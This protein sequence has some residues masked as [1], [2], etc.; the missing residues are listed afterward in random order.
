M[1]EEIELHPELMKN[2]EI[3][4]LWGRY[5]KIDEEIILLNLELYGKTGDAKVDEG[6]SLKEDVGLIEKWKGWADKPIARSLGQTQ[7]SRI[8]IMDKMSTKDRL[9]KEMTDT[10]FEIL[11]ISKI[12][13]DKPKEVKE[14][15]PE[16][17]LT[18]DDMKE[19]ERLKEEF[20]KGKEIGKD[21]QRI[22]KGK[23][24]TILRWKPKEEQPR[25]VAIV[26]EAY[27]RCLKESD[28]KILEDKKNDEKPMT[29]V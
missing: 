7:I 28:E 5:K 3:T 13:V 11:K 17:K 22:K 16:Y 10:F 23:V 9:Y 12:A 14:E 21:T 27:K 1:T 18:E 15:L 4:K 6:L 19:V 26:K 29:E 8:I 20:K 25:A 2:P 24:S